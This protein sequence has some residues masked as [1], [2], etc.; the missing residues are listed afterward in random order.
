LPVA[1]YPEADS[2]SSERIHA[3]RHRP[4]LASDK[5]PAGCRRIDADCPGQRRSGPRLGASIQAGES[6]CS[7][8]ALR[9]EGAADL[10]LL[11]II[12]VAA[13]VCPAFPTGR[14]HSVNGSERTVIGASSINSGTSPRVRSVWEPDPVTTTG[15]T[16]S[17]PRAAVCP[18]CREEGQARP[19][20]ATARHSGTRP[21]DA[22]TW[23]M[24]PGPGGA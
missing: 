24:L 6:R 21:P 5:S 9:A 22:K 14:L 23:R 12:L 20:G 15:T 8:A 16:G 17:I 3:A 7:E 10:R 4:S 2:A 18:C 1:G 13:Y 11:M 19:S